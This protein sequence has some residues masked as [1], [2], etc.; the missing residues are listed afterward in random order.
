[1]KSHIDWHIEIICGLNRHQASG[2]SNLIQSFSSPDR[3]R[4]S[5]AP[6]YYLWKLSNNPIKNGIVALAINKKNNIIASTTA[7]Y[8]TVWFNK[9]SHRACEFGD[10]YT[11]PNYQKQGIMTK[12]VKKATKEV[13]KDDV[14][15]I[16]TTPNN[17]SI[18]G[19]EKRGF[20]M[21]KSNFPL[22]F[23][24]FPISPFHVISRSYSIFKPFCVLDNLYKP[25][26]RMLA[27]FK[28][29]VEIKPLSFDNSYDQLN[30]K[31]IK[32]YPFLI[33]K[34][35]NYLQYRYVLN[36]DSEYYGLLESRN[37]IGELEASLIYKKCFQNSMK[38][39]FITDIFGINSS[40]LSKVWI[41]ALRFALEQG[42]HLV[43][44][45]G[46]KKWKMVNSF[47]PLIPIPISKKNLLFYKSKQGLEILKENSEILFSIGDTDNV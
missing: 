20:F 12:L 8:K 6:D 9:K 17:K 41:S 37:K 42:Y 32:V 25:V 35:A 11:D 18:N 13:L 27:S 21:K 30:Q 39:L 33:S 36:P 45:W 46:S 29:K 34:D 38:V 19:Y 4:R 26:I 43:A 24:A 31:M 22:Y 10:S 1:M 3:Q 23:M 28:R 47:S 14:N 44:L 7:T 16:Y 2:I 5:H 40:S 15:I